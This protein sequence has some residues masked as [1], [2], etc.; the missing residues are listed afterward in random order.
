MAD[1]LQHRFDQAVARSQSLPKQPPA[2]LLDLYGLFK[3]AT[4]GDVTGKQP[5][6]LD[7]KGRAKFDAWASRRGLPA[8]A[9]QEAYVALVDKLAGPA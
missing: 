3:Q 1:T 6:A 7:F 8:A 9:A 2:V 5:G 4:A